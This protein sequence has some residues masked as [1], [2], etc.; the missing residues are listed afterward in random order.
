MS[1]S[2]KLIDDVDY[3]DIRSKIT[4]VMGIGNIDPATNQVDPTYG[5]G[6]T[7]ISSPVAEGDMIT[8]IQWDALRF[9]L[10]NARIHQDG[11][12]PSIIEAVRGQPIRFG[13]ANPN[14]QYDLQSMTAISN[15]FKLG[16]GQFVINAASNGSSTVSPVS[17]TTA[18]SNQVSCTVTVNFSDVNHPRYFF[19]SG[20]KIR[21]AS[22]R[23]G[24]AA[25]AQNTNWST[26]LNTI[27]I[28]EFGAVSTSP[29]RPNFYS[30]TSTYQNLINQSGSSYYSG[31][32]FS[33]QVRSNSPVQ[34]QFLVTW[35][36]QYTDRFPATPP[37][38]TVDGTLTL[39][40]DEV[41]AFGIL[42]PTA[43]DAVRIGVPTPGNF[44]IVRPSF[45]IS[46]I[47]GS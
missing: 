47:S 12:E 17:R 4:S 30:L 37:F 32:S 13:V 44:S 11:V 21:L 1:I 33:I 34:I 6:Q 29:G 40:I 26:L 22:S 31:N 43:Q 5:Y 14:L 46:S 8:K 42:L 24:G 25:T 2:R 36:D 35:S 9:D 38:D 7:V 20:S 45:V 28:V 39:T 16:A 23:T 27:G 15:R 10:L 41:R 3:N 19:N 18:W